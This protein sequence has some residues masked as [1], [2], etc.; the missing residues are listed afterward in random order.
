MK[1]PFVFRKTLS[2]PVR[3]NLLTVLFIYID[4]TIHNVLNQ[5]PTPNVHDIVRQG[6]K[7]RVNRTHLR[8]AQP[9]SLL[10]QM[11]ACMA[12]RPRVADET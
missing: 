4:G 9:S 3:A 8:W 12:C 1:S 10:E 5:K 11:Q 7:V 2:Q 6:W